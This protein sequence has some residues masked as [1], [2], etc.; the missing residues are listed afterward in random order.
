MPTLELPELDSEQ[1][2]RIIQMALS[3]RYL[4]EKIRAAKEDK[5][6]NTQGVDTTTIL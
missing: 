4:K 3:A 6:G 5:S 2:H 1:Q